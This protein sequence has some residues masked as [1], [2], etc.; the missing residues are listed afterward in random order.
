MSVAVSTSVSRT[1]SAWPSA[2][3]PTLSWKAPA[4]QD[5]DFSRNCTAAALWTAAEEVPFLATLDYIRQSLPEN[6]SPPP[7][8]YQIIEWFTSN[9]VYGNQTIYTTMRTSALQNCQ[10]QVCE[11]LDWEGIADLAGIGMVI[12]YFL[13]A[14]IATFL[15]FA[16]SLDHYLAGRPHHRNLFSRL[17]FPKLGVHQRLLAAMYGCLDEFLN[18]ATVFSLSLLAASVFENS[19]NTLTSGVYAT[20]YATLL[21][22]VLPVFS[23][24]PIAIV[25]ATSRG[26]LRRA[27]LR[28]AIWILLAV[29]VV[30]VC[31]L[32]FVTLDLIR[33]SRSRSGGGFY[34]SLSPQQN[35]ELWCAPRSEESSVRVVVSLSM[36]TFGA[37]ALFWFVLVRDFKV[38]GI[39]FFPSSNAA[40]LGA[41]RRYWWLAV[42]LVNLAGMWA[43][44]ALF[45]QYR[46][47]IVERAGSSQQD[48]RWSVGQVLALATWAPWVVDFLYILIRK[49]THL[50]NPR[51]CAN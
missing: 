1:A 42:A 16:M 32:A 39:P 22:V 13:Q 45:T 11:A 20:V 18:S 21:T 31:I 3:S 34:T 14:I 47:L 23:V 48:S 12:T 6:F 44:L 5:F 19:Y 41:A 2:T 29:L 8:D 28:T 9:V 36:L 26:T 10:Y 35:F 7:T 38:L 33:K 24:F 17:G 37:A 30:V 50:I 43:F 25:Q 4:I 40:I 46:R 15:F 27:R 51:G 49:F